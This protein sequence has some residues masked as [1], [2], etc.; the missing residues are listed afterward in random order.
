MKKE[1]ETTYNYTH[2]AFRIVHN[3]TIYRRRDKSIT[4]QIKSVIDHVD[5]ASATETTDKGLITDR[6]KPYRL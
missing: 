5:R 4:D 6:F 1:E 3:M 2:N